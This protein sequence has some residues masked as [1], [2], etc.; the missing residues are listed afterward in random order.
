DLDPGG[1]PLE[2]APGPRL[3]DAGPRPVA[4]SSHPP[5][6]SALDAYTHVPY[7][8]DYYD[9]S[10]YMA[11]RVAVG[12]WLLDDSTPGFNW[13]SS[14]ISQTLG[15]V[16]AGL[17]NWVRKGGAPTFLTFFIESHTNVPVSGIPIQ[18][19]MSMDETWVNEALGNLG[20]TGANGFEKCFAYNHSIRDAFAANWCYS[21]FIADSDPSVNQ[22]LFSGGGYA[23]AYYGG[24]WVY[25]SR[26][27]T[28]AYNYTRYYGVVPM[29]ESGHIFMDTDE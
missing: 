21:I 24:P 19:P 28:W 6:P 7:G 9:T 23:W 4:L 22:G 11:G 13:T 27:S 5:G 20:W 10:E 25:M 15:G 8:A 1:E 29:H 14:E 17:D 12:V 26:Y 16:Q 2:S 18:N 3:A